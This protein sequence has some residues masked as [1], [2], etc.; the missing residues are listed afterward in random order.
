VNVAVAI[1]GRAL[2][3]AAHEIAGVEVGLRKQSVVLEE[4]R[5]CAGV[6]FRKQPME[7]NS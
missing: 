4:L 3:V 6:F 5:L 7:Q 2:Q 1:P